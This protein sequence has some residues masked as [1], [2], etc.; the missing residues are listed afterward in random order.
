MEDPNT[1]ASL[2]PLRSVMSSAC[3]GP[4]TNVYLKPAWASIKTTCL[5]KS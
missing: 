3:E 2:L 1:A 4:Q 5:V